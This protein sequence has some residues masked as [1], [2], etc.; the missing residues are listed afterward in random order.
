MFLVEKCYIQQDGAPLRYHSEARKF[1]NVKFPARW[2]GRGVRAK[3]DTVWEKG[4]VSIA[5]TR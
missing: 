3:I 5:I 1:L 2:T 4:S